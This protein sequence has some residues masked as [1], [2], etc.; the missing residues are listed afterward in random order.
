MFI[1]KSVSDALSLETLF[2]LLMIL[3]DARFMKIWHPLSKRKNRERLSK[4]LSFSE[5]PENNKNHL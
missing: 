3:S 1:V 2:I 4:L 5:G